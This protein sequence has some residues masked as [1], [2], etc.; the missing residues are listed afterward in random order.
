MLPISSFYPEYSKVNRNKQVGGMYCVALQASLV[1][2][3]TTAHRFK[4]WDV[5]FTI[6][7]DVFDK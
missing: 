2:N 3:S 4:I 1:Y 5:P 7:T 6:W